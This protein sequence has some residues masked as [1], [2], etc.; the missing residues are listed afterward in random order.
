MVGPEMYSI[1]ARPFTYASR[2]R[3]LSFR[4]KLDRS[5]SDREALSAF[6]LLRSRFGLSASSWTP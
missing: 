3:L 4:R 2:R 1:I 5:R 6:N